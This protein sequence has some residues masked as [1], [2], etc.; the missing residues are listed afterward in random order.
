MERKSIV[1]LPEPDRSPLD[2]TGQG[3]RGEHRGRSADE[4]EQGRSLG[5]SP[6]WALQERPGRAG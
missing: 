3:H 2:A 1:M 4:E 6:H 5:Q